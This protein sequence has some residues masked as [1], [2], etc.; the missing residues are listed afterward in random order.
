MKEKLKPC[1]FCG[2]E[3]ETKRSY[4][5]GHPIFKTRCSNAVCCASRTQ[6]YTDPDL[7]EDKWNTR[8]E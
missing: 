6:S 4:S 3:A 5:A 1:P 2:S 7:S 8:V